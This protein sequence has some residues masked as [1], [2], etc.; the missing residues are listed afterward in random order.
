YTDASTG[1]LIVTVTTPVKKGSDLLGVVG[2]DID[3]GTLG[4]IVRSVD[5][6]GTGFAFL[7]NDKG[8][9]LIHPNKDNTLKP[10]SEVFPEN[11]PVVGQGLGDANFDDDLIFAFFK[12]EG[13]PTVN[14]YLGFAVERNKA[15]SSLNKF[16][17][18]AIIAALFAVLTVIIVIAVL[19]NYLVGRPVTN[20]TQVMTALAEGNLDTDIQVSDK[21][22]EVSNM[23]RAVLVFKDQ[24]IEKQRLEIAH[25]ESQR[26]AEEERKAALINMADSFE[27]EVGGIV[28][29]VDQAAD[30]L[31][32][33][34]QTMSS[35]TQ[36][37][38]QNAEQ[39]SDAAHSI[40]ANVESVAAAS[41]ELATSIAEISAQVSS[42]SREASNAAE[43]GQTSTNDV[44]GLSERVSEIS[45]IVNL[46]SDIA[47][48]TNLLALNATIEAARAGEAGKG[49]AVVANEVKSLAS[50]T[51]NATSQ[52]GDQ[53]NAVV[54]ATSET[55]GGIENINGVIGRIQE[56]SSAIAAAV[57]EQGAATSEIASRASQTAADVGLVSSTVAEVKSGAQGNVGRAQEVLNASDTLKSQARSLNDTLQNF[58]GKIRNEA[59]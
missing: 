40:T 51:A 34:A 28:R 12:V 32:G 18:T 31:Q 1:G 46:I 14:W 35:A 3:I 22:D 56:T 49:F 9:I 25:Q 33:L 5:L 2:G 13:L 38:G 30:S 37:V 26:K 39:A 29:L 53:I 57:E 23:A 47:D 16:T 19:T 8:D 50:Q 44:R 45:Q 15:F 17:T 24:A 10:L 48:Q 43:L 59:S 21:K 4:D 41:E 42:S 58:V 20:I 27:S 36:E 55:V 7:A 54:A 11:T 6:G 52:I